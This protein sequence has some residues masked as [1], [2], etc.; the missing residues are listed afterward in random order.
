MLPPKVC[1]RVHSIVF[2]CKHQNIGNNTKLLATHWCFPESLI[3]S[4]INH[5]R[6]NSSLTCLFTFLGLNCNKC[7]RQTL[8][9]VSLYVYWLK[10]VSVYGTSR[11]NAIYLLLHPLYII[12]IDTSPQHGVFPSSFWSRAHTFIVRIRATQ[13][14]TIYSYKMVTKVL[15]TLTSNTTWKTPYSF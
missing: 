4:A 6:L 3:C 13:L 8:M 14:H 1:S 15:L 12:S 7:H 2:V 10:N 11:P 9:S 5:I